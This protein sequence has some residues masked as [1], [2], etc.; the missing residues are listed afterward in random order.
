MLHLE[1]DAWS[2]AKRLRQA[3]TEYAP[4]PKK[5]KTDRKGNRTV[6]PPEQQAALPK[7]PLLRAVPALV[8]EQPGV[9]VPA[10][11][12]GYT[13]VLRKLILRRHC[14]FHCSRG[15]FAHHHITATQGGRGGRQETENG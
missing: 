4:S 1:G 15:C 9:T 14:L 8:A 5:I 12:L 2:I 6:H 11:L 10:A 7:G 3:A 13:I